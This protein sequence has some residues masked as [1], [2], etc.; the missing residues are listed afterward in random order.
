MI[1]EVFL[2][3]NE[4]VI[5][6]SS[7][8]HKLYVLLRQWVFCFGDKLASFRLVKWTR[9]CKSNVLFMNRNFKILWC[10]FPWIVKFCE[11]SNLTLLLSF[12]ADAFAIL[13]YTV[14]WSMT[15][16]HIDCYDWERTLIHLNLTGIHFHNSDYWLMCQ[17][18]TPLLCILYSQLENTSFRI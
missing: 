8:E 18:P 6:N 3:L 4:S 2:N 12:L 11:L 14:P 10:I 16:Y 17:K 1:L 7:S 5:L 15:K 13:I 9:H